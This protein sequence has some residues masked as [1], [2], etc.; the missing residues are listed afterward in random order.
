MMQLD[1]PEIRHAKLQLQSPVSSKRRLSPVQP[2]TM[3]ASPASSSPA[4]S[5]TAP[6]D[7]SP[8]TSTFGSSGEVN[9]SAATTTP[10]TSPMGPNERATPRRREADYD[11]SLHKIRSTTP[12]YETK[13]YEQHHEDEHVTL[14]LDDYDSQEEE[15]NW[16]RDDD[17]DDDD[18][19]VSLQGSPICDDM[20]EQLR[21]MGF[22]ETIA[23]AATEA[24]DDVSVAVQYACDHPISK[25]NT[26]KGRASSS[27]VSDMGYS[28][29]TQDFSPSSDLGKL[30]AKS[31]RS[32]KIIEEKNPPPR[33]TSA[34][35]A[36]SF[37]SSSSSTTVPR[38]SS[39]SSSSS[40]S[41]TA[42]TS[43]CATS[44]CSPTTSKSSASFPASR[45]ERQEQLAH[46][47]LSIGFNNHEVDA[48]VLRCNSTP[49]AARFIIDGGVKGW[50]QKTADVSFE[51]AI[52][53]DDELDA[54]D[55]VTL[56]CLHRYCRNCLTYHIKSLMDTHQIKESQMTCPVPGCKH[57]V[58][59]P[60]IQ[61]LIP[62]VDYQR[63]LELKL[64]KEYAS[65]HAEVRTCP[66]C[67][68][69]VII[70]EP[71]MEEV[72]EE[73]EEKVTKNERD[74]K[75]VEEGKVGEEKVGEEKVGEEKVGEE[76]VG[77]GNVEGK[78]EVPAKARKRNVRR[79]GK[80]YRRAAARLAVS[81]LSTAEAKVQQKPQRR[82]S[83]AEKN[84]QKLL[85]SLECL[86]KEC[87]HK[88]CG[89]CG[90]APHRRQKDQDI[91]CK[92]FAAFCEAND[93]SNEIFEEYLKENKM[94]RCPKCLLPAELKSGCNFIR[95]VCKSSYCYLCGRGLEESSHYS[96]FHKGP[97]GKKCYGGG[98]DKKGNVAQPAC[99]KCKGKDCQK[100]SDKLEKDKKI[101][102][103]RIQAKRDK[104]QANG[105]NGFI[106]WI[107]KRFGKDRRK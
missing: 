55:M 52:C 3:V 78:E 45:T 41:S 11:N 19:V 26:S 13:H 72:E 88:F 34:K 44:F 31:V 37:T 9:I 50:E 29:K 83:I 82:I 57:P 24:C 102:L 58:A 8:A 42:T 6:S 81:S 62:K 64:R 33:P 103:D 97:Y 95:C 100:C 16:D 70:E 36:A 22:R 94:K 68:Y 77:E 20:L 63:L 39:T 75:K 104:R 67:E 84:I 30:N 91:S 7:A 2:F 56:D 46:K 14:K 25:R 51:C 53:M 28:S 18:E 35:A 93:A 89:R 74:S 76:K 66:K 47:L 87:K 86:N 85:D 40:Y 60:I 61:S 80:G 59:L 54:E 43:T 96:H 69:M 49:A 32:W 38:S 105:R 79:R 12:E 17:A 101:K 90:L 48:A 27:T 92:D 10:T 99:E 106:G 5:D 107:N 98:K 65:E 4:S 73:E 23:R 71:L 21:N 15:T 1:E